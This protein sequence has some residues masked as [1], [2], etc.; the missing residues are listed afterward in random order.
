MIILNIIIILF[1]VMETANILILYLNPATKLGNGVGV[2]KSYHENQDKE[3]NRLFI[4]YL[5]R[6]VANA[7]VIF[8]ALLIVI[9]ITAPEQVKLYSCIATTASIAMYFITLHPIIKQLDN[10]GLISPKGY[11]K[12]LFFMITGFI[13]MFIVGI[14]LYY[15]I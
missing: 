8:I 15:I 12:G 5:I 10:D 7:K 1:I 11:S 6:W 2:F 3:D 4:K 14:T 9:L 13:A